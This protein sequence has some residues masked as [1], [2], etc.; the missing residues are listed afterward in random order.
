MGLFE[1]IVSNAKQAANVVGK[2]TG[3]LV[4]TSK[5]KLQAVDLNLSLIH[6]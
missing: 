2:K 5:L 3:E 6:I 1:N 4:D